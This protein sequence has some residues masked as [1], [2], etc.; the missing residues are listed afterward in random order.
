MLVDK[1]NIPKLKRKVKELTKRKIRIGVLGNQELAMVAGSN[2]Y[3]IKI[4][5]TEKMRKYLHIL[6]LHL[7]KTTKFIII[8]ERSFLRKS[9]DDKKNISKVMNIAEGIFKNEL[10]G[11]ITNKIGVFMTGAIQNK[12]KSNIPPG[13][14]PF[15]VTRKD[16]K[17]KTLVDKGRLGQGISHKVV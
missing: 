1:N 5:V 10:V 16:G 7:K 8:P 2:E 15:T 6:G 17:N 11:R 4:K 3:G 14:H 12:I 13:N 9:F